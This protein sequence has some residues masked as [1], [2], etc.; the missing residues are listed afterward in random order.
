MS[1]LS[2]NFFAPF[3]QL[4][5]FSIAPQRVVFLALIG[6]AIGFLF[7]N[8]YLIAVASRSAQSSTPGGDTAPLLPPAYSTSR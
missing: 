2:M 5:L 4:Q 6:L 3:H 1:V 8:Q 7:V